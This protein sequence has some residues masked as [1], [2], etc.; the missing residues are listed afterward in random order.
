MLSFTSKLEIKYCN[1]MQ[2]KE[3]NLSLN[4]Y[5]FLSAGE[6]YTAQKPLW[7]A[8]PGTKQSASSAA[9]DGS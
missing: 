4:T 3:T 9:T 5:L 2:L 8:L 1:N 7:M 6:L